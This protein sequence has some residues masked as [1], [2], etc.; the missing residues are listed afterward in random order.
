MKMEEYMYI[1]NPKM[2]ITDL[3]EIEKRGNKQELD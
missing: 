2:I 1:A 3:I